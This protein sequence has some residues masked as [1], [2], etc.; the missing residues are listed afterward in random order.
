MKIKNKI[1]NL[2]PIEKNRIKQKLQ[3][4]H[5]NV[6]KKI[7]AIIISILCYK[8]ATYINF[9][10]TSV[11]IMDLN[12][13]FSLKNKN[14]KSNNITVALCTMAKLENLY[15]NEFVGYHLKLGIDHIFIY[16]DNDPNG[17]KISD[18]IPIEYKNKTTVIENIKKMNLNNQPESFTHCYQNNVNK[19]DWFVMI[20]MDEFIYI[21]NGTL[22]DYLTNNKFNKCDFIRF[23]W[24]STNDNGLVHYDNRS[25]FERF[26]PPYFK[27]EFIKNFIRGDIPNLKYWVHSPKFS[28]NRNITCI[29]TGDLF[30]GDFTTERDFKINIKESFIIHFRYKSTEEFIAK[31]KR[32]LSNW[33]GNRE[34]EL[35]IL[36]RKLEDY[37]E[38]NKIT[39]EKLDYVGKELNKSL[40]LYRIKY[41]ISKLSI[42]F[43]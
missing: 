22:K 16:D 34:N 15:V 28:P 41:Y 35:A 23:H 37:F 9:K 14:P 19:F 39:L 6:I 13:K 30:H 4:I 33:F 3:I 5:F 25:L 42:L 21:V 11:Y 12:E 20:D 24:V 10:K 17:E 18:A 7:I 27:I 8:F 40:L 38:L 31:Y 2:F 32:G 29:N 36:N 43:Y 1:E 26:K